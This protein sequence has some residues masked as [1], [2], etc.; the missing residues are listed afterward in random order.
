[1]RRNTK[2]LV[3]FTCVHAVL[4]VGAMSYGFAAGMVRFDHP[5]LPPMFGASIAQATANILIL[6]GALLW[7]SWASRNLPNAF[8]WALF[9][10]NSVL[11]GAVTLALTN[12]MSRLRRG[13]PA[14]GGVS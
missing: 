6:P 11:W 1:M 8:E 2:L 10:A 4:T 9:L 5:D 3:V 13:A 14:V 7:T 12:A